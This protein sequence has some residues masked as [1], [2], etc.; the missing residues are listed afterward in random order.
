MVARGA[1]RKT[2]WNDEIFNVSRSSGGAT[3]PLLIMQD[4][5]DT[6]KRGCTIGRMIIG[7]DVEPASPGSVSGTQNVFMGVGLSS[8]DAFAGGSTAD[9]EDQADYPVQGWLW[10]YYTSVRDNPTIAGVQGRRIDVDLRALRKMD[11][12]SVWIAFVNNVREGTSFSV[13]YT[14]LVRTLYKLP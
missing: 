2:A 7:L 12:S 6:E 3:N 1:R 13:Q 14:G 11:R 4:L 9:P 10:R 8:D 5:S